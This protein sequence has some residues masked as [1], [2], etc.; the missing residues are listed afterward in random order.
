MVPPPT[1]SSADP[2]ERPGDW[3]VGSFSLTAPWLVDLDAMRWRR[4]IDVRRARVQASV[5]QLLHRHRMPPGHRVVT[6]GGHLAM[7]VARWR[8]GTRRRGGTGSRR[9]M[10]RRL[11]LAFADLG[12]TF[13]KLGQIISNGKG[14]FPEELTDEMSELRD[15]V[16]PEQWA[17]VERV[18]TEDLGR[19]L[20][21][22]FSH[23]EH[24]PLAAASIAQVHLATLLDG[25]EVVVK[26]QR[27][28]VAK[29][30]LHDL[31]AMSWLAPF[32]IGRI[33]VTALA[34]PPALVEVFAETIVE[35]LDFRLEAQNMLDVARIL[36]ETEHRAVIVPRPHPEL[37]TERIL[38]MER[39]EGFNFDDVE[40]M[41]AAGVDTVEVMRAL[42]ICLLEG[43]M[44]YGIFHG[45]L[46]GGNLFVRND[47]TVALLDHGITGRLSTPR[48]QAFLRLMMN[49]TTNNLRGQVEAI[50]DLG[51]LPPDTDIDAVIRD[52]GLDGSRGDPTKMSP[53]EMMK[54]VQQIIK[55]LL[56][57]GA[58]L[59]KPLMLFVKDM[60]FMDG[61]VGSLAPDI[62][63]FKEF[64]RIAMLFA[65]KHGKRITA[66]VGMDAAELDFTDQGFRQ[67]AG[68]AD[69]EES[70][71]YRDLQARRELIRQRMEGHAR[72]SR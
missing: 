27:P 21:R 18:L 45:D 11:R 72:R 53:E 44:L 54:E 29:R 26:V 42:A 47:G 46:H 28:T 20:H 4:G 17:D 30:V 1:D 2:T 69:Q 14:I 49:G 68:V 48:R 24:T 31:T 41:R 55:A 62:D 35:E 15:K 43:C 5:P 63:L 71:T 12:P 32:L 38:V 3:A 51:S 59:P 13:I 60:L 39:L 40:G 57:Y 33:P 52:V 9:S 58:R 34:N 16:P 25:T 66:D 7:A 8:F 70:M 61:A 36:A 37:V 50:R 23:I 65:A 56:G 22:V 6:V 10:S 67:M 64:T 19:P